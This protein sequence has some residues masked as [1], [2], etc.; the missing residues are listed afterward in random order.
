MTWTVI[1]RS[2][3][4]SSALATEVFHGT[5]GRDETIS[6]VTKKIDSEVL[7]IVAGVQVIHF[8]EPVVSNLLSK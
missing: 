4:D 3:E 8:N 2:P 5:W 1:Y 7:A 6:F